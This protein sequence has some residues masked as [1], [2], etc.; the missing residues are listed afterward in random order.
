VKSTQ[1]LPS[2]YILY[3]NFRPTK[4]RKTNWVLYL[5]G[6]ALA[7]LSYS[8]LRRLAEILRPDFQPHPLQFQTPTLERLGAILVLAGI[9]AIVFAV[10]ELIHAIFL[11]FFTR[12]F[13]S[14]V[15]GAG[16]LAIRLHG[17]YIPRDEFLI[18]NLAPFVV[19]TLLGV[20]LL[21]A[22]PQSDIS[23]IV[24][25]TAMNIAGSIFDIFSS[26]YLFLHPP[27]IYLETEGKIY[28]N[29]NAD[30]NAV[31]AWKVRARSLIESA[32]NKLDPINGAD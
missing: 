12:Y 18:A 8:F 9:L 23:L 25:F 6:I 27:S 24:F 11:Y 31:P 14:L 3:I 15:A 21:P 16:G 1:T 19:I 22:V 29:E 20:F 5:L 7:W 13:P 30:F 17:W 32:I 26:A 28:F 10:H 2:A 4:W